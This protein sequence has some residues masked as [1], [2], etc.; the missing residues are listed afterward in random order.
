MSHYS[1]T[2][3]QVSI[4]LVLHLPRWGRRVKRQK[5]IIHRGAFRKGARGETVLPS[6]FSL[7]ESVSRSEKSER[8]YIGFVAIFKNLISSTRYFTTK[9]MKRK[10]L[11]RDPIFQQKRRIEKISFFEGKSTQFC[12]EVITFTS[13]SGSDTSSPPTALN[14]SSDFIMQCWK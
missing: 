1:P 4:F 3:P 10:W 12:R 9:W 5:K 8:K 13:A 2:I 11:W 6:R 7:Y 14:S